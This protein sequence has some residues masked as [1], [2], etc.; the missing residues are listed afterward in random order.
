MQASIINQIAREICEQFKCI[1]F[2]VRGSWGTHDLKADCIKPGEYEMA[3]L[4]FLVSGFSFKGRIWIALDEGKDLYEI[5][6]QR[7]GAHQK[8][9][10]DED[11]FCEDLGDIL[12][13][14]IEKGNERGRD[15]YAKEHTFSEVV[16]SI[17][18]GVP[19]GEEPEDIPC[20]EVTTTAATAAT[21]VPDASPSV[22]DPAPAPSA[23]PRRRKF[24]FADMA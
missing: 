13:H 6:G 3:A 15:F 14:I 12:D 9:L 20:E 18:S 17:I 10:L 4:S 11:V 7:H 21:T 23:T 22:T 24:S 8:S 1:P 16:N 19:I 5:W 2:A